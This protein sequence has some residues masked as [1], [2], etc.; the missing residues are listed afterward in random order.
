MGRFEGT[1]ALVTGGGAG[2]GRATALRMA[3]EGASV[4]LADVRPERAATVE[5]EVK[6]LGG[7][8]LA[9]ECDVTRVADNERMVE[10]TERAFGRLD[11]LVTSAGVGE[12]RDVVA[13]PEDRLDFVLDLDL[14]SPMLSSRFAIPAMRRNGGGAI[15]HISS[16][17]GLRANAFSVFCAAKAGI[18]GLTQ[19]MA[20][21][22]VRDGIRVNCVCPG[23]VRTPLTEAWLSDPEAL[24]RAAAWHPMGRIGTPEEV[25]AA[26]CFLASPEASFITGVALP[27]DGG[28][29]AAGLAWR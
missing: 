11:I 1:V 21:A 19:S 20:L 8:G 28:H 15:I 4:A 24:R 12:S 29:A 18:V 25:A 3:S 2:I 5:G 6:A 22:H 9:L 7:Q 17:Q 23:V 16:I 13:I 14:K 27:V 26:I 10:A